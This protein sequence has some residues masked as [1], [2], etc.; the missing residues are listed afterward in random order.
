MDAPKAD[1][2]DIIRWLQ[3]NAIPLRHLKAGNGFADLRPLKQLLND[4]RCVGL[5]ESTHGTREFFQLKHRL[6]EFLVTEMNFTVFAIE[7]SHAACQPINDYVLHGRGKRA[8]VLAGQHYVV[9]DTQEFGALLD[10]LRAHNQGPPETRKVSFYGL[11]LSY[12]ENGRQAVLAYIGRVAPERIAATA[13]L[14]RVLAQEEEKWPTRIDAQSESAVRTVLP[15]LQDLIAYLRKN[16]SE[17]ARRSSA[18]ELDRV[19]QFAEVMQQWWLDGATGRSRHMAENLL[20]VLD[21]EHADAKTIIWAHN[22]HVGS[23]T[24]WDGEPSLGLVLREKYGEAYFGCAFEFNQGSY[25]SRTLLPD[26]VLGDLKVGELSAPPPGTLPW[27]LS[28]VGNDAF[29]V[30]L[31]SQPA[32]SAVER[33]LTSP[34]IQHA[35]GWVYEEP[36]TCYEEVTIRQQYDGIVF[37]EGM[38]PTRPTATA[39]ET[40]ARREGL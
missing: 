40:V 35:T 19:Q 30:N 25:R 8:A 34:Q 21:R 27:Y 24:P 29:I 32:S 18:A 4:V 17:L 28:R 33:W 13:A 6:V 31:R 23:G 15:E 20:R 11:D 3:Q 9:W 26:G 5:G 2:R 38:T 7:A 22:V 10:W 12:N 14:F 16:G 36:S 37:V 39:L 1:E